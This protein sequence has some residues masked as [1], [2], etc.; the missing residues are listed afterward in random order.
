MPPKSTSLRMQHFDEE[1]YSAEPTTLLYRIIDAMCNDAGAGTL[2]KKLF[3]KRLSASLDGIYGNSLDY[4]FGGVRFL[5]RNSSESYAA[6]PDT[7]SLTSDEWDEI[8]VKD[9]AY[10]DRITR[11]FQAASM[12]GTAEGIRQAVL[13]ATSADCQVM[14]AWRYIDAF[15]I[16]EGVGRSLVTAYAAVDMASGHK[17]YFVDDDPGL[18]RSQAEAFVDGRT[19]WEVQE[20]RSRNEVVVVPHKSGYGPAENRIV[21]DMLDR[22]TP[23]DTVITIS[24]QGLVVNIP[25]G[26]QAIASDSTFFQVEKIVTGSPD[27]ESLP[28]PE[29]LAI[30]LDPTEKWL[31]SRSP[32]IAPYARFNITSEYG[33]HYLISND[34]SSPI[35]SVSYGTLAADGTVS[36]EENFEWYEPVEEFGPWT[37]YPTSS[38]PDY[39]S[40][41]EFVAARK[42]EIIALGGQADDLRYRL[43]MQGTSSL[44]RTFT[45]D[46]AV[47][48]TPPVQES[49]VTGCWITQRIRSARSELRNPA[50][51]VR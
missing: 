1:T 5:S 10:R 49:T 8:A 38:N 14:E 19:G 16:S 32:E 31:F 34:S 29:L 30:D 21:R 33:Y 13:A 47:A 12:G 42:A 46:L 26:I 18:A 43:P 3:L 51:F 15:G 4:I 22:I 25:V 9:A 35:D 44:K 6:N 48:A 36:P 20:Q 39:A 17:V 7:A 41:A 27:L 37:P 11:F 50:S 2:K 28:P 23:Q 40:Q 24:T 45:P